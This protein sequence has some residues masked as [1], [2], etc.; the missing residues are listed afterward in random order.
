MGLPSEYTLQPLLTADYSDV[1][2]GFIGVYAFDTLSIFNVLEV[3][4]PNGP[5][6]SF[7]GGPAPL[8]SPNG[9][10]PDS[11]R[12]SDN[13]AN[14]IHART[15]LRQFVPVAV[16]LSTFYGHFL[17]LL[18]THFLKKRTNQCLEIL[19]YIQVY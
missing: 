16:R 11:L 14:A 9:C 3:T 10:P 2:V 8:T 18:C 6:K 17:Y 1:P 12:L 19:L 4:I 15:A 7:A 5:I 13:Y